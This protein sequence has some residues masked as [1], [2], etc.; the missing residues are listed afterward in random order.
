MAEDEPILIERCHLFDTHSTLFRGVSPKGSPIF[1][2]QSILNALLLN[3]PH[4]EFSNLVYVFSA[5]LVGKEVFV[6]F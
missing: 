2:N 6:S 1:P 5:V 4:K 3:R